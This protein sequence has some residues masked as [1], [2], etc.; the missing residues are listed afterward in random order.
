MISSLSVYLTLHMALCIYVI[1]IV[2]DHS[3]IEVIFTCV[4]FG[5]ATILFYFVNFLVGFHIMLW[6]RG[7]TTVKYLM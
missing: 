3:V 2:K 7:L 5:I 4:S 1:V 6:K